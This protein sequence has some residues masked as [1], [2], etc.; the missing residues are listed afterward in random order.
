MHALAAVYRALNDHLQGR[1]RSRNV[2]AE[3]VFSLNPN[4]NVRFEGLWMHTLYPT[5]ADLRRILADKYV[6]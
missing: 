2:H 6:C 1:R 5:V 4:N 3:I